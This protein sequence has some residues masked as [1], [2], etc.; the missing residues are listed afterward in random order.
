MIDSLLMECMIKNIT[1]RIIEQEII[2]NKMDDDPDVQALIRKR[3]ISLE[4]ERDSYLR[5]LKT[6]KI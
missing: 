5:I 1:E 3:I 4:V 2:Y 6:Y